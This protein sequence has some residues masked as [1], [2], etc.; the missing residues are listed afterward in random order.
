MCA[1][2]EIAGPNCE[3][4]TASFRLGEFKPSANPPNGNS[5]PHLPW[6]TFSATCRMASVRA[7]TDCAPTTPNRPPRM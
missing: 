6:L 2:L 1:T 5:A 4:Y 3:A 7:S